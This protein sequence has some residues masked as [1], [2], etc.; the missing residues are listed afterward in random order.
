M[1]MVVVGWWV[2]AALG[3]PG[4]LGLGGFALTT[5]TL[6]I[7]NAG[8]LSGTSDMVLALALFYGGIAQFIAGT[9]THTHPPRIAARCVL[10]RESAL[11]GCTSTRSPTR[12]APQPSAA[13][14][15]SGA[16][17]PLTSSSSCPDCL[18][19]PHAHARTRARHALDTE[20][21]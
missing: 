5:M 17:S 4:P 1:V 12:S 2:A 16:A 20:A 15:P 9:D 8:I 10:T 18:L 3:N 11:Q 14:A 19:V 21:H 7:Y 13:T 6:S